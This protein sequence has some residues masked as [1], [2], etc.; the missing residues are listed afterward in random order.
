MPNQV[1]QKC[2][3]GI[4]QEYFSHSGIVSRP[5]E[6]QNAEFKMGSRKIMRHQYGIL[7]DA[8]QQIFTRQIGAVGLTSVLLLRIDMM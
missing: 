8:M 1:H 7:L 6:T 2:S 3:A 5:A 4:V